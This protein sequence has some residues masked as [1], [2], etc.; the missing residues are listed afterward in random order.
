[1]AQPASG[2][3]GTDG[4]DV[5]AAGDERARVAWVALA[6]VL[7][8]VIAMAVKYL[9]F[10]VTGSVALYSDALEGI[11]NVITGVLA[12][13]AVR[14]SS[15]PPDRHHQFGHHKAEYFSAALEGLMILVAAV[16]ILN[17]A[18]EAIQSPRS[19]SAPA[20]GLAISGVATALN[21]GWAQFLIR[22][23][24]KMR[25]PA[26]VADGHH[27]M[28]DVLTSVGVIAGLIVAWATGLA[29]LDPIIAAIVALNILWTGWRLTRSSL[30]SL[31]DEAP[32]RDVQRRIEAAIREN[33]EGAIE[34]HDLKTRNAG[35]AV[36]VEFH[37]VVPGA[38]TVEASHRICDRL[39]K[40]IA[41]E[42]EGAQIIIHVEPDGEGGH[43]RAIPL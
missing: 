41:A 23:G 37:L 13:L 22:W 42:V 43:Q 38:M 1:V 30:S 20:L 12:F 24:G 10:V 3:R 19:L 9:A 27:I 33:G 31:M 7:V 39:E 16:L 26:L 29:I 25:S 28:T 14:I 6:S 17:E 5:T 18:W 40:A 8:A 36:F 15:R 11:V 34:A 4:A 21:A 35:S 2:N 32:A